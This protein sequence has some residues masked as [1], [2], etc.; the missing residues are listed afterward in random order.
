MLCDHSRSILAAL[1]SAVGIVSQVHVRS[2]FRIG[3][4]DET[5]A[6]ASYGGAS[7][8]LIVHQTI[9]ASSSLANTVL[10][11]L[12]IAPYPFISRKNSNLSKGLGYL[13]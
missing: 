4:D 10:F 13:S 7:T 5:F 12:F 9:E 11:L 2:G 6:R 8:V 1:G 3:V